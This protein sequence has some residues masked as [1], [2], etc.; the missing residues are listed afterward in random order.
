MSLIRKH[1]FLQY[2]S[3]KFSFLKRLSN[4]RKVFMQ[5]LHGRPVLLSGTEEGVLAGWWVLMTRVVSQWVGRRQSAS[6]YGVAGIIGI[7]GIPCLV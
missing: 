6:G 5:Q 2:S 3:P 1:F 7:G 4:K